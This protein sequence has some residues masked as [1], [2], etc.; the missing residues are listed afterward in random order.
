M[1]AQGVDLLQVT[2]RW[3]NCLL[4][5]YAAAVSA[6]AVSAAA[7]SAA[8]AVSAAAAISDSTLVLLLSLL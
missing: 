3:M 4:M 1:E 6:A 2:F 7:F 8:A 5:R